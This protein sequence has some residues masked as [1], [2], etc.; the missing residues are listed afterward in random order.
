MFE[1]DCVVKLRVGEIV[2]FY[3]IE[4]VESCIEIVVIF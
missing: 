4:I 3:L 1:W 2:C